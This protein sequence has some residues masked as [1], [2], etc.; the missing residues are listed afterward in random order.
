MKNGTGSF[1]KIASQKYHVLGNDDK[2]RLASKGQSIKEDKL[3]TKLEVKRAGARIF[4][5]VANLVS[6]LGNYLPLQYVFCIC[7]TP[8]TMYSRPS[9]YPNSMGPALIQICGYVQ[10]Q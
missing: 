3:M 4:N 1:N 8:V 9:H 6:S 5:K 10:F 2:Q 7:H